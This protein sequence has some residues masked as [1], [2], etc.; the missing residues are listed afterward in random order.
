MPK[1]IKHWIGL[2]WK[3]CPVSKATPPAR[4]V[5]IIHGKSWLLQI[6][7]WNLHRK[8]KKIVHRVDKKLPTKNVFHHG[9]IIL[10]SFT[11]FMIIFLQFLTTQEEAMYI[12]M[13]LRSSYYWSQSD[14]SLCIVDQCVYLG[15]ILYLNG[16]YIVYTWIWILKR[17]TCILLMVGLLYHYILPLDKGGTFLKPQTV[18]SGL[19]FLFY[20]WPFKVVNVKGCLGQTFV[21]K[22]YSLSKILRDAK[23]KF[24]EGFLFL[25]IT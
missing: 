17:E 25:S 23:R 12:R 8:R 19:Q 13:H 3:K 15:T 6:S 14:L 1:Q 7:T 10:V 22:F 20:I 2:V 16:P 18:V 24:R 5:Q 21:D 4:F 9:V 11:F